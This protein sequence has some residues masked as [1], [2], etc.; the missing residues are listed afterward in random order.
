MFMSVYAIKQMMLWVSD[1]WSFI[2]N[3]LFSTHTLTPKVSM[4]SYNC[5]S[6][7]T[8]ARELVLTAQL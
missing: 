6:N 3:D 7:M 2:I 8:C 5:D 4:S 1:F